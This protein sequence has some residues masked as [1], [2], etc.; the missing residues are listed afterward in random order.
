M[1]LAAERASARKICRLFV[2]V[3]FLLFAVRS[4]DNRPGAV[5]LLAGA[6]G[7]G[8]RAAVDE[9]LLRVIGAAETIRVIIVIRNPE[10]TILPVALIAP[11]IA[12]VGT[13]GIEAVISA[14][15]SGRYRLV[16]RAPC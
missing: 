14:C 12:G 13:A 3:V 2:M 15:C 11:L 1:A 6:A 8:L 9:N 10:G 5:G 16:R 4:T 7:C